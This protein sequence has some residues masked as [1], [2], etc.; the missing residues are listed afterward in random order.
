MDAGGGVFQRLAASGTNIKDLDIVLLSHLYIDHTEVCQNLGVIHGP[1]PSLAFR[2][3]YCGLSI[4]YSGD[5][6]NIIVLARY[7][8]L[9]IYDTTIMD[10]LSDG[11]D[12]GVFFLLHTTPTR[13]GGVTA[14]SRSK[15]LVLSQITPITEPS[16]HEVKTLIRAQGYQGRIDV[17]EDLKVYNLKHRSEQ[18]YRD[19]LE[20][21]D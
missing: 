6:N 10:D 12:G 21:D 7:A 14:L 3:E 5:T 18:G 15:R 17:A 9:L 16:M 8:D 19:Y 11:P 2:I 4:D 1:V 13:I 20:E